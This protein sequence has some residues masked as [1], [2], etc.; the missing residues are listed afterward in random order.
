MNTFTLAGKSLDAKNNPAYAG[1]Y[2]VFRIT[3]VGSDTAGGA[4]YPRESVDMLIAADGT[5]GGDLWVN[6]DSGLECLYEVIEPSGQRIEL[7]FPSAVDATTVRYEFALDNYLAS[8]SAAQQT[9]GLAAHIA[10]TN[11]P[12]AVTPTQLGLVIGTDVQAYDSTILVDADIGS[13][14]QAHST[15]LDS[16]TASY[17]TAEET[18]LSGIEALAEVNDPTT[19]LD[20][21]IGVNVQAHNSILDTVETTITD[22]D[23]AIPTSGAVVDYVASAGGAVS[24]VN[25]A[26]GVVV[27]DGTDIELVDGGGT[28]ISTA[29]SDLDSTKAD[30]ATLTQS[31]GNVTG[32]INTTANTFTLTSSG[33][34]SG[35]VAT[36]T[37]WDSAGDLVVGT[38]SDAA[39]KLPIGTNGQVLTSNGTTATW[40][41]AGSG[42]GDMSASTYDPNTVAA[43]AFS[44][45]NMVEGTNAKILTSTE[46]SNIASNTV[47]IATLGPT[48]AYP[49]TTDFQS[50]VA[51]TRDL[52]N[53]DNLDGY[54]NNSNLTS[55]YIGSK[56]VSINFQA[57]SGA[58]S[59]TSVTIPS[60]VTTLGQSAF[61]GSGL[62]SITIPDSVTSIGSSSLESCADLLTVVIGN[63]V[64][65]IPGFAIGNNPLL[66]SVTLGSSVAS[67]GASAFQSDVALTSIS[68][69]SGVTSIGSNAFNGC[70]ALASISI[71]SPAAPTLGSNAFLSV[72]ATTVQVPIG[73]T[74]YSATYGGLTVVY[75]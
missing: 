19:V 56:V 22:T 10:D 48:S 5:F 13:T 34:G 46:R 43:D 73:A 52:S 8:T 60:T 58:D 30:K 11:N 20:A 25:G 12:H 6:G 51:Q 33:G 32:S 2:M 7:I 17:T 65:S 15:A 1:R 67:I 57:F 24:S 26:T 28:T 74:G 39:V 36:D 47:A 59:L 16:T 71:D 70:T 61:Y 64:A 45:N 4:S 37:I 62:T 21:D 72:S 38:G 66:S 75:V 55:I 27:V 18:K 31:G 14:V 68:I 42:G 50:G 29:V 35:D 23:T 49:Y 44:M 54:K 9:P 53:I 41:S 3:S 69:P 40:A 63:N